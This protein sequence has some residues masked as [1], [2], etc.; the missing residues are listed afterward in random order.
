[1]FTLFTESEFN[2][3][4]TLASPSEGENP[5]ENTFIPAFLGVESIGFS[6][7]KITI[8]FKDSDKK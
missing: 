3:G 6:Q 2:K 4:K 1:M 8:A 7:G 5:S